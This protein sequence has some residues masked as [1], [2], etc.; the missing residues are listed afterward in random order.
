MSTTSNLRIE[1]MTGD[2]VDA[3]VDDLAR[4]RMTV[5]AEYP[6]LY[7]GDAAYERAYLR[8][9]LSARDAV[10]VVACS[11]GQVVGIAT[12]SPMTAQEAELREPIAAAG[13]DPAQ[14]CYFGES[15]LLPQ[16][17]GHGIGRAF[18]DHREDHARRCGAR[19]AAFAAV[20][21]APDH[22]ARP[23]DYRELVPFWRRRG[24]EAIPGLTANLHWQEHGEDRESPKPMQF[25][26]RDLG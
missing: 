4:L 23:A 20:V 17:R 16:W 13:F 11:E 12:A 19:Y 8:A 24:Y 1:R 25:W 7:V 18:F 9:F 26:L 14:M 15:V 22:P 6:Y 10:A 21:R 2:A 5:F 3:I